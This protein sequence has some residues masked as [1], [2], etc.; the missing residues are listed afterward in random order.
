MAIARNSEALDQH[1]AE[2]VR[3]LH[4]T[5]QRAISRAGGDSAFV[6]WAVEDCKDLLQVV[7]DGNV[8]EWIV[9]RPPS[10]EES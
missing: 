3:A 7:L 8:S 6:D 9:E 1:L 10:D 2:V 4:L 5:V